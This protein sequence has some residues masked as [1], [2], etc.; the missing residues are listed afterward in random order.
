MKKQI[1]MK[2]VY[3]LICP[4]CGKKRQV[5][6]ST[7]LDF[8]NRKRLGRCRSCGT[9][10]TLRKKEKKTKTMNCCGCTLTVA[11]GDRVQ[12]STRCEKFEVCK[13]SSECLRVLFKL[14]WDGFTADCRGFEVKD[15]EEP[16]KLQF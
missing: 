10:E 14:D 1:C 11:K 13:Y 12:G 2:D 4:D 3:F 9:K 15:Y 6:R 8:I 16:L 7:Y 5:T